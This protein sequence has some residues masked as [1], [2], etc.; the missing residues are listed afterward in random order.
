VQEITRTLR[1]CS[2]ESDLRN[3]FFTQNSSNARK[4]DTSPLEAFACPNPRLPLLE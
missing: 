4:G 1:V 3:S 2:V